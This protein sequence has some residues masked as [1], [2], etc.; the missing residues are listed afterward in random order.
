SAGEDD[1]RHRDLF[2]VPVG[3]LP[4]TAVHGVSGCDGRAGADE[5]AQLCGGLLRRDFTDIGDSDQAAAD[6]AYVPALSS[7]CAG[8]EKRRLV[9]TPGTVACNRGERSDG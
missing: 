7:G 9:Q 6:P 3:G 2:E 4:G 5:R 1:V 8:A